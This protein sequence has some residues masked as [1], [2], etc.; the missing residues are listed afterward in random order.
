M[1]NKNSFDERNFFSR[2]KNFGKNYDKARY[3]HWTYNSIIYRIFVKFVESCYS[4]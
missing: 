3:N 4:L 1:K 2:L